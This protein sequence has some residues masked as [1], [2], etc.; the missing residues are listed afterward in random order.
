M[1]LIPK[2]CEKPSMSPHSDVVQNTLAKQ[3]AF[4]AGRLRNFLAQ[5]EGLTSDSE[6][7][8]ENS[9]V[10]NKEFEEYPENCQRNHTEKGL[11]FDLEIGTKKR[12]KSINVTLHMILGTKV[13]A[14]SQHAS[15]QA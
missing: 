11:E 10:T 9:H 8:E 5:W 6:N 3:T 1:P 13:I 15:Q 14:R 4:Q 12:H 2:V 7:L